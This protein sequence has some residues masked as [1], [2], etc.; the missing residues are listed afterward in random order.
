VRRCYLDEN[1][2]VG[3]PIENVPRD[4]LKGDATIVMI[5]RRLSAVSNAKL[6]GL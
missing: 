1:V 4:K 2:V 6:M 5:A 3:F